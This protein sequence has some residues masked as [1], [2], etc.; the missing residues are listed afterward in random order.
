[1]LE[2]AGGWWV[3][4]VISCVFKDTGA[5]EIYSSLFVGSVRCVEEKGRGEE[6]RGEDRRGEEKRGEE[7]RG[8]ERRAVISIYE[9][10]RPD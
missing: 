2:V 6:R 5:T 1:M 8:E 10:T 3:V 7:R 9:R 4:R